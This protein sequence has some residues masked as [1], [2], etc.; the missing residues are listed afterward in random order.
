MVRFI[1]G[2][3]APFH[4]ECVF[5]F[6]L[7]PWNLRSMEEIGCME[8]W[9]GLILAVIQK[10][11]VKKK[12]LSGK[13]LQSHYVSY[14][15]SFDGL[16]TRSDMSKEKL[17]IIQSLVHN[18]SWKYRHQTTNEWREWERDKRTW[19]NV[20]DIKIQ[21]VNVALMKCLSHC[22]NSFSLTYLSDLISTLN[23]ALSWTFHRFVPMKL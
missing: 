22:E 14:E 13:R 6:E 11:S 5:R 12:S 2:N 10:A 9:P 17:S 20:E 15:L 21:V 4:N 19:S 18:L 1:R 8:E 23:R 3:T 16:S 7:T